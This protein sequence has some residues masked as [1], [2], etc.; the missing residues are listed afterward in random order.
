MTGMKRFLTGFAAIIFTITAPVYSGEPTGSA[1]AEPP[2]RIVW[3]GILEDG[4]SEAK[5][6]GRP[7]LFVSGAP[8]C[9]GV[10]GIW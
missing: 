6:S 9:L 5:R 7:I 1:V 8:Q 2:A 3:Y 10:S 4:L